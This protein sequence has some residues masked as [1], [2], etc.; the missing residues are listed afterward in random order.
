MSVERVVESS[1]SGVALIL[2]ILYLAHRIP[3]PPNKGDKIRSYHQ[4]SY[5]AERHEVWCAFF[6]DDPKD[7]Q[8]LPAMRWLCKEVHAVASSRRRLM[9]RGAVG[10]VLGR[11]MTASAYA[12]RA[13]ARGV[14]SWCEKIDFDAAVF[15]SS[16]MARYREMV[17]ARRKVLDFC[18]WDSLKWRAYA[19]MAA[20]PMRWLYRVEADRLG[21]AERRWIE[22]FDACTV[23]T[24]R[25]REALGDVGLR[26]RV[27]VVGNGVD[28]VD[29]H[30]AG[31]EKDGPRV[32]F[33][34]QMDYGPNVEAVTW[35][36][37]H[38][39]PAV[40]RE[41]P[42]AEFR[43]VGRSPTRRVRAL[44]GLAGIRVTGEVADPAEHVAGFDVSVAPMR[45][46][47]GV[48][49]KVLES[50][51]A[52]RPVVLTSAAA[53]GIDAVDGDHF[54]VRDD[55]RTMT[56]DLVSLL[57]DPSAGREL[58]LAG[59]RHV[60]ERYS[61]DREMGKFEALLRG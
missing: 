42:G 9:V 51:A 17:R 47:R 27:H 31:G 14:R 10:M 56:K 15:F 19:E 29:S 26:S 8:Y 28:S 58:G 54:V 1:H 43:I 59:K 21:R 25:E 39:W 6:V 33:V 22:E 52:G 35:F 13:F 45:V 49:N 46:G 55:P 57:R 61:W 4:L 41:V 53:E 20:V 40:R 44:G 32:G 48:Q 18:D 38:V 24:D 3:Y 12:D 11:S 30:F 50:M 37:E 5:L 7:M 34:G 60:A 36:A 2:R 16:G 23:V